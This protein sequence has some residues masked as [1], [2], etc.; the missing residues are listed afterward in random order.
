MGRGKLAALIGLGILWGILTYGLDWLFTNEATV[1][2]TFETTY[3]E[4]GILLAVT[5]F[6]NAVVM[7]PSGRL[8]DRLGKKPV[9]IVSFLALA[10]CYFSY[11]FALV[12]EPL[13]VLYLVGSIRMVFAATAWVALLAWIADSSSE[14]YRGTIMS[15][16]TAGLT[17]ANIGAV[18]VIGV[19]YQYTSLYMVFVIVAAAQFIAF[20]P[21][22]FISG[23]TSNEPIPKAKNTKPTKEENL[24]TWREVI[25]D[26]PLMLL[27]ISAM[28]STAPGLL[29]QTQI[30][31]YLE[32][33]Y[34]FTLADMIIP[35]GFM[36]LFTGL[37]FGISAVVIDKLKIKR[38][39]LIGS[40]IATLLPLFFLY[41]TPSLA[42]M[43][44]IVAFVIF[45]GL[46]GLGI[47]ASTP[48][49]LAIM[50]DMAPSKEMGT[51]MGVFQGILNFNYVI[52]RGL[53]GPLWDIGGLSLGML[54]SMVLVIV[55]L[56]LVAGAVRRSVFETRKQK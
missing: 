45:F 1:T 27:S 34:G 52:G 4:I 20:T 3:T 53:G 39:L 44:S 24:R 17:V 13:P 10:V 54:A 9:V 8:A 21:L 2:I 49:Y 28:L 23:A 18:F 35:L 56:A 14:K 55:A 32:T 43:Q 26:S 31:P 37:G 7:L 33:T 47:G 51:E 12:Y 11:T 25:H 50:A 30:V 22:L 48:T 46:F 36:L 38:G 6:I 29:I 41:L 40:L 5:A 16:V 15:A 19:L 42:F